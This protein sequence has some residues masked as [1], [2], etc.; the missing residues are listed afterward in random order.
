MGSYFGFSCS[1]TTLYKL[2][3]EWKGDILANINRRCKEENTIVATLDNN[4]NNFT[5]HYQKDGK[6]SEMSKVT[7]TVLYGLNA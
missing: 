7:A 5:K 6:S 1:Y 4:Q 3:K 2:F